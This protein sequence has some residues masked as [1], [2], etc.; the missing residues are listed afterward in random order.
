MGPLAPLA[1]VLALALFHGRVGPQPA[2]SAEQQSSQAQSQ[3]SGGGGGGGAGWSTTPLAIPSTFY[4]F[5]S[6]Q[7]T[8]AHTATSTT[9]SD[10]TGMSSAQPQ[11]VTSTSTGSSGTFS[12]A[13]WP[14]PVYNPYVASPES[15]GKTVRPG[16]QL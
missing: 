13:S 15:L 4:A 12:G 1:V 7:L 9:T 14:P 2:K 5:Q 10:F 16:Q 6:S 11:L 3:D 8:Q